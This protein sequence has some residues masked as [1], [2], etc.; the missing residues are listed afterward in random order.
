MRHDVRRVPIYGHRR[1]CARFCGIVANCRR[2]CKAVGPKLALRAVCACTAGHQWAV[3][4]VVCLG[5]SPYAGKYAEPSKD[6]S[7]QFHLRVTTNFAAAVSLGFQVVGGKLC[8]L[9]N[10]DYVSG[11]ALWSWWSWRADCS[12]IRVHSFCGAGR[13]ARVHSHLDEI[14]R[15]SEGSG[16]RFVRCVSKQTN[17]VLVLPRKLSSD[18]YDGRGGGYHSALLDANRVAK[19][20]VFAHRTAVLRVVAAHRER[21]R[22][23]R[24]CLFRAARHVP[25]QL[26]EF[27]VVLER[28]IARIKFRRSRQKRVTPHVHAARAR[29]ESL[30]GSREPHGVECFC[31]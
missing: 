11:F 14:S 27:S 4:H 18:D 10:F 30:A 25:R 31:A 12:A 3:F 22:V 13:V 29:V 9:F 2:C 6:A 5:K 15:G 16:K 8:V 17:S 23:L 20:L 26:G 7:D 1:G 21:N 19:A 24:L 28:S